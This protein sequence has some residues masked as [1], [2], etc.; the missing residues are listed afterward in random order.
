MIPPVDIFIIIRNLNIA[1]SLLSKKEKEDLLLLNLRGSTISY[2]TGSHKQALTISQYS[3]ILLKQLY[4][5]DHWKKEYEISLQNYK[6]IC[7]L[8]FLFKKYDE[9]EIIYKEAI[10]NISNILDL[11]EFGRLRLSLFLNDKKFSKCIEIGIQLVN[12]LNTDDFISVDLS[13]SDALDKLECFLKKFNV[14]NIHKMIDD[15]PRNNDPKI[16]LYNE[17]IG[18]LNPVCYLSKCFSLYVALP[19][20]GLQF[21]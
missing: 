2:S 18:T 14:R 12:L 1:P 4:G 11:V 17:I 8:K 21:A 15:L 16:I 6:I 10:E 5:N 3:V 20:T 19:L 9:S 13:L 7:E